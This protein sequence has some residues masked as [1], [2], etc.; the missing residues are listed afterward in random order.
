MLFG[1]CLI[2]TNR[3]RSQRICKHEKIGHGYVTQY[4][5]LKGISPINIKPKLDSSQKESAPSF[6][7]IKHNGSV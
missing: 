1:I 6:A 5:H 3:E 7:I 4:F 2:A